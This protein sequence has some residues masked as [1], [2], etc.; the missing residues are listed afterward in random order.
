MSEPAEE[1]R[2]VQSV[3]REA[4]GRV[5]CSE[6]S[7]LLAKGAQLTGSLAFYTSTSYSA[8]VQTAS[9]ETALDYILVAQ[10][11]MY[12]HIFNEEHGRSSETGDVG[13]SLAMQDI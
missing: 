7:I 12:V 6:R 10:I 11:C 9:S 4:G 8:L 5:G 2:A 3:L 13:D 1:G